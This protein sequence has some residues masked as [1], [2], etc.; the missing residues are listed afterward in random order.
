MKKVHV[1]IFIFAVLLHSSCSFLGEE[2]Q[3]VLT[4]ETVTAIENLDNLCIAAYAA[5]GNDHYTSPLSL[6]PYGSVRSDDAYKGGRDE[7]DIQE[8]HFVE[9]ASDIQ[10]NFANPDELWYLCYVGIGRANTAI[11]AL[12]HY[13]SLAFPL[14]DQRIAEMRFIRGHFHFLLKQL[15]KH[16]PYIAEDIPAQGFESLK[17]MPETERVIAYINN[18]SNIT[19]SN[20]SLWALIAADFRYGYEH[21]PQI[22]KEIGR[23]TQYAAAAYLAKTMLYKAYRQDEQH[24]V[25]EI[26]ADD[27]KQVITY[28]DIVLN[29][30]HQLESDYARNFLPETE[31]GIESIFAIQF[32]TG[33]GSKFGRVNTSDVL[34]FPLG[35]GGCDFHKPSQN[36]VNAFKTTNGLPQ[37]DYFN[38]SNYGYSGSSP[39]NNYNNAEGEVDTRLYHTVALPGYPFKYDYSI[40]EQSWNRNI[41]V[42]G[43]YA[44]MK[45]CVSPESDA[46]IE[47]PPFLATSMNRIVIR[48]AD[49]LL[50]RA[51]ALIELNQDLNHARDL[52]NQVR[53]RARLSTQHIPYARNC[54]I[55]LYPAE[56]NNQELLRTALRWERR[57]E[58]AMEGSRF[59]D[60]TRWGIAAE[61]MNAYYLREQ[62]LRTY[63]Q[64]AI[65]DKNKEEYLPI[66]LQQISFSKGL[67]KQNY[68]Y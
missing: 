36:L 9:I 64:G 48:Y 6:W 24:N 13:D 32:S 63:M 49:V 39:L 25:V 2:P 21:L 26:N 42:Y 19:Y 23:P 40:Y 4:E 54:R 33:D 61:V 29:S 3:G 66:P 68:G 35:I 45:E 47:M 44:T 65:F 60:L 53:D 8:Y 31:N 67:Y 27:L 30:H 55:D 18:V 10:T 7:S 62:T 34:N 50:W 11:R 15:F 20:D 38:D 57:M 56:Y 22:Q 46:F 41:P 16:I 43:I 17:D 59:F 37:F 28:T 58:F 12:Q 14:R 52:I 1:I 5:L 51:E